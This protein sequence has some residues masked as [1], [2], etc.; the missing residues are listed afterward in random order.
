MSIQNNNYDQY[1][2]YMEEHKSYIPEFILL[3]SN[4]KYSD[5]KSTITLLNFTKN[6]LNINNFSIDLNACINLM[7]KQLIHILTSHK[8]NDKI[9]EL[10]KTILS[11]M[12]MN[13]NANKTLS[14]MAKFLNIDNESQILEILLISIQNFI[15]NSKN[16]KTNKYSN[17]EAI[18]MK[19]LLDLFITEI[20]NL[21]KHQ[22]SEIRKR[23][24]YCCVEIHFAIG[25][26][27]EP[28]LNQIPKNQQNLIRLFI[29]K[30][31]EK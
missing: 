1:I 18:S 13:L 31:A 19:N 23:A 21:L 16:K 28:F 8:N 6:L 26:D 25:K 17:N 22:N 15:T 24:V 29:K 10:I 20:F 14:S 2:L 7:V 12:P 11:D 4:K 9:V 3:L 30:R 27:F 5:D